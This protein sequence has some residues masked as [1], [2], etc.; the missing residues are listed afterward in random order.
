MASPFFTTE[1]SEPSFEFDQLRFITVKS[2]ALR[3]RADLTVFV[4]PVESYHTDLPI[5]ILLHG[6]YGSH[7]AW[8]FKGG[9]HQT[10]LKLIQ[11]HDIA[12]MVI[13]MPSDGLWWDGSGYLSHTNG[14]DY[15]RWIVEEVPAV[16]REQISSVSNQ[17]KCYIAGLSMGGYGALRLGAKYPHIFSGFSGLSSMTA[18]EQFGLFHQNG[19]ETIAA[20]VKMP[21]D[22]AEVLLSNRSTLRPF[23]FDCGRD[24]LLLDANR[25]LHHTLTES[26]IPHTYQEYAGGH[27]WAYWHDN[28]EHSLRFFDQIAK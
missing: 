1:I 16:V 23:R 14:M 28:I 26:A 11:S 25:K 10:A 3:G 8:A 9:V 20:A 24:D 22:V 17:S 5:V 27:E 18:F 15:E 12:P 4:P 2:N 19:T 6:V 7:W 21:E 13:V